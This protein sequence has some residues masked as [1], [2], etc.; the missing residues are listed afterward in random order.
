VIEAT[1]PQPWH[2]YAMDNIRR[3]DEKLAGKPSLGIDKPTEIQVSGGLEVAGPW[4]Q[5]PP[6]DYSKPEMRWYTWG[7]ENKAEFVTKVRRSGAEPAVISVKGQACTEKT[8]K[9]IDITIPMSVAA[10]PAKGEMDL[11]GLVAVR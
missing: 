11:K 9:G 6:K 8:C 4:H 10:F 7:F 3:A 5:T 1:L 2:T